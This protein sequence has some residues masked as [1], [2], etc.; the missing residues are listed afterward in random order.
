MVLMGWLTV[1]SRGRK[2]KNRLN[3]LRQQKEV[4]KDPFLT[5]LAEKP[6]ATQC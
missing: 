1:P 4:G 5:Y 2:R 3:I 6:K